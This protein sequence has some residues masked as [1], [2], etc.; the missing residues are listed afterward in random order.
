MKCIS[1][2]CFIILTF[3]VTFSTSFKIEEN[4]LDANQFLRIHIRANS[5]ETSDQ[6]V[7]YAVKN[8]VVEVITPLLVNCNNKEEVINIINVNKQLIERTSNEILSKN[9]FSY[10]T[11][12]VI[13][14]EYFPT[15]IYDDVVLQSGTYDAIIL[16]LGNAEGNNWWCVVYPPLCF[17]NQTGSTNIVYKSKLL[18]II[19][20]FFK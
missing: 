7:K 16:E 20:K 4:V 14:K 1:L 18:E 9:S 11:K 3:L 6:V 10:N 8:K 15:R 19:E 13:K 2:I 5:N 17:V 12:V